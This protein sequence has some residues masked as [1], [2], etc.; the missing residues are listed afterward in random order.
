MHVHAL[1]D[2]EAIRAFLESDR[3]WAAYGL[4]DLDPDLHKQSEWY[5]AEDE[6]GLQS[7]ALLYKGFRLPALF[8]MGQAQGIALIL[9]A[10]LREPRVSLNARQEHMPA[11]QA[12]YRVHDLDP[13]WRMTLSSS[14][15]R[16]VSGRVV[17]LTPQYTQDLQELYAL[18]GGD[19]FTPGQVYDGAFY[20]IDERGRLIAAAGTHVLSEVHGAAAVGNVFTHPDYRGKGYAT[21]T[22]SAVCAELIRRGIRTIVLNVARSNATAI[23][24]YEKLG[25][26]RYLPFN[27]G[28]ALRKSTR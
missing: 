11:I 19:A 16:P 23:R 26:K 12:H 25:F 1:V 13:M 17:M 20:G 18:G 8:T 22:T 4:A 9:A 14:D 6:R 27:E 5:G 10:A 28:V 21:L 2:P 24:V 3:L 7:L 15:F